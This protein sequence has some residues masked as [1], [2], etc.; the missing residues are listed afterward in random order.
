[1]R[2]PFIDLLNTH[3]QFVTIANRMSSVPARHLATGHYVAISYRP[4]LFSAFAC[5]SGTRGTI[6]L[7]HLLVMPWSESLPTTCTMHSFNRH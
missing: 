3:T 2:D 7:T 4:M 1:M 5:T 6:K